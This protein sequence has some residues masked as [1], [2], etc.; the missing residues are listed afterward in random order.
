MRSGSNGMACGTPPPSQTLRWRGDGINTEVAG[1]RLES[2]NTT[3]AGTCSGLLTSVVG[4]LKWCFCVC[5]V[6]RTLGG[7]EVYSS[8]RAGAGSPAKICRVSEEEPW[9][10]FSPA[11]NHGGFRRYEHQRR[12]S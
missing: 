10:A 2:N 4:L 5:R 1:N 11:R 6:E 12:M 9:L 3:Q 8:K 7:T